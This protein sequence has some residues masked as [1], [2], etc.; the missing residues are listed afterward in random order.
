MLSI[1]EHRHLVCISSE[2]IILYYISSDSCD[3]V[4]VLMA[5]IVQSLCVFTI[6]VMI[7]RKVIRYSYVSHITVLFITCNSLPMANTLAQRNVSTH[8]T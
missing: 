4:S 1:R 6:N 7:Q 8:K 2:G 5:S 3:L